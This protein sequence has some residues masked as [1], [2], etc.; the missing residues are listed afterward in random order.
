MDSH[1]PVSRLMLY[2]RRRRLR[3]AP[4]RC[5]S[6]LLFL[7]SP[8]IFATPAF[9]IFLLRIYNIASA[10]RQE[11]DGR[12]QAPIEFQY[13]YSKS[14]KKYVHCRIT[15]VLWRDMRYRRPSRSHAIINMMISRGLLRRMSIEAQ[16]I[17]RSRRWMRHACCRAPFPPPP[18]AS[19][20]L[21]SSLP[22]SLYHARYF[23]LLPRQRY[24]TLRSVLFTRR[25]HEAYHL[26]ETTTVSSCRCSR[27]FVAKMH[28]E[29]RRR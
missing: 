4:A 14:S 5:C 8:I 2:F 29:R 21:S 1:F 27:R 10:P 16:R 17:T 7:L 3:H 19:I 26:I 28:V 24:G 6:F 23:T 18:Y 11:E 25:R 9:H 13:A 20:A 15:R 22:P 12:K